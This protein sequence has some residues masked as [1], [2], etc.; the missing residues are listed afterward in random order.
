LSDLGKGIKLEVETIA[1]IP[2]WYILA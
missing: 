1:R 2:D